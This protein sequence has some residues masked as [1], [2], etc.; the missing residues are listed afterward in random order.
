MKKTKKDYHLRP[1]VSVRC[2]AAETILLNQA[3]VQLGTSRAALLRRSALALVHQLQREGTL[4]L[5]AAA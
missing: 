4:A 5:E 2:T 1:P 3:A